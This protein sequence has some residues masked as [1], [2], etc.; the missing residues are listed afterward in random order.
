MGTR[1]GL[2]EGAGALCVCKAA[3]H[4][5]VVFFVLRLLSRPLPATVIATTLLLHASFLPSAHA[6]TALSLLGPPSPSLQSN[7]YS[8]PEDRVRESSRNMFEDE[9]NRRIA[10][11][12]GQVSML[13]EVGEGGDGGRKGCA[14]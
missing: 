9:N 4:V 7:Y 2:G 1:Q 11:L 10:D 12:A 8:T 5:C 3:G 6:C 13:K 14:E